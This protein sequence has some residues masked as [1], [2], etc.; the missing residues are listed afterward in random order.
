LAGL[1]RDCRPSWGFPPLDSPHEF[2][3]DAVRESPPRAPGCVAV[4]LASRL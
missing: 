2:G 4:P 3:L 1:S